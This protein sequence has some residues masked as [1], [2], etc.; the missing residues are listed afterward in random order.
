MLLALLLLAV[1]S[2]LT[3]QK[4]LLLLELGERSHQL[5]A[6]PRNAAPRHNET[7]TRF[8]PRKSQMLILLHD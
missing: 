7:G 8:D 3:L 5:L 6:E 1:P 2:E 4:L